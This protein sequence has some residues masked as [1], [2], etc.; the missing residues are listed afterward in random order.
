ME[1]IGSTW[2]WAGFAG[3][4]VVATATNQGGTA[5]A[6]IAED[7]FAP[8][9][10][11]SDLDEPRFEG[12]RVHIIPE[13]KEALDAFR[14]AGFEVMVCGGPNVDAHE[15]PVVRGEPCP[16]MAAAD[17]VLFDLDGA[18]QRLG[19][20]HPEHLSAVQLTGVYHNLLRRWSEL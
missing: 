1:T 4:V 6:Q 8:H 14:D 11:K 15:C 13:V 19:R 9:N 7:K 2:M 18:I 10:R 16:L 3:F 17:I 12:G 5:T 20:D